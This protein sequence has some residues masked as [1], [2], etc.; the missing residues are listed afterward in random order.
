MGRPSAAIIQR[1]HRDSKSHESPYTSKHTP[2][3]SNNKSSK[4]RR[5]KIQTPTKLHPP[6][7][8]R[9]QRKAQ[10]ASTIGDT[11]HFLFYGDDIAEVRPGTVRIFFQNVRGITSTQD[12]EDTAHIMSIM[13]DLHV[14][15]MG[16]AETQTPWKISDLRSKYHNRGRREFGMIKSA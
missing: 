16:L 1:T 13:N 7:R 3:D 4:S 14:D 10:N 8:T 6:K 11:N 12:D 9:H 2:P 5:Q 15:V